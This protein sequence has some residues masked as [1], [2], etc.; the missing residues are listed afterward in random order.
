MAEN[1]RHVPYPVDRLRPR[2]VVA[3]YDRLIVTYSARDRTTYVLCPPG[4][5]CPEGESSATVLDAA[6]KVLPDESYQALAWHLGSVTSWDWTRE[7]AASSKPSSSL[8][9]QLVNRPALPTRPRRRGPGWPAR[10]GRGR[11][12]R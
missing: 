7:A 9:V 10:P 2:I 5:L 3:D 11:A 6:R 4:Q 12:R 1:S 8:T